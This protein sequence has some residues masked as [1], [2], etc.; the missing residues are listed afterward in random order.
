VGAL[1]AAG[2]ASGQKGLPDAP[3]ARHE[4]P[5]TFIALAALDLSMTL[6]DTM[7]TADALRKG[8][9]EENPLERPFTQLPKGAFVALTVAD[10]AGVDYLAYR[11]KRSSGW[12]RRI[13]WAPEVAHAAIAAAG[14]GWSETHERGADDPFRWHQRR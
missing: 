8:Y 9:R 2:V 13:W 1:L 11:L 6:V 10:C 5:R 12:E 14:I 7:Q 4:A 3:E